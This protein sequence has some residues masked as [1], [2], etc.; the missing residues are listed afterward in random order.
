MR[1]E[2]LHIVYISELAQAHGHTV[3]ADVC[4]TARARNA[5]RGIAGV[6]LFDGQRF[7]QWLYG[8]REAVLQ[9]MGSILHDPR[10]SAVE[11][12]FQAPRLLPARDLELQWSAGFIDAQALDVLAAVGNSDDSLMVA[13][14]ARLL[15]QAD[16]EPPMDLSALGMAAAPG[17]AGAAA[18]SVS[19]LCRDAPG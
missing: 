11:V 5:E 4:R 17:D 14:L 10:H 1:P 8:A 2:H 12:L 7:M 3:F 18:A 15:A 9:L 16:L 13:A 6:L 19:G